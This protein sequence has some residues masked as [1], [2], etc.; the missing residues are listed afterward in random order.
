M[1]NPTRFDHQVAWITGGGSGLGAALALRFAS[2]GAQV[3]VSGRREDRL[4]QTVAAITAQGGRALAVPCDVRS[5]AQ[6]AAA[7]AQ[8]LTRFGRL[9]VVVANAGFTVTGAIAELSASDWQRQFDVNVFGTTHVLRHTLPHLHASRG[10]IALV[11]SVASHV[12]SAG[13]VAYSASKAAVWA[14]G[15]G[16]S[17]EL[18]GTGVSCTTF[19]PGLIA[20]EIGQVDNAGVYRPDLVDPRPQWLMW[21]TDRAARVMVEA[22]ARRRREVVITGHGRLLIA[23]AR[24]CPGLLFRLVAG[25]G[26]RASG[27]GARP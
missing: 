9:D 7:V 25:A 1:W 22:I 2:L 19:V 21:P 5:D 15:L 10:R 27:I 20:S 4:A 24:W 18:A 13:V 14:I 26:T 8:I 3:V 23:L 11:S 6:V 17:A 16:L 12:P